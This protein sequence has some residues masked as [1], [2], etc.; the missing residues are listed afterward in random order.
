M[1]AKLQALSA[2]SSLPQWRVIS[3]AIDCYL[4]RRPEP[5]RQRVQELLGPVR[6]A[7]TRRRR[8]RH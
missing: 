5:D 1:K 3:E 8:P 7:A 2:V 6:R 4:R